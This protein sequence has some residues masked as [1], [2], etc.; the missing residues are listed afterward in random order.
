MIASGIWAAVFKPL[1]MWAG[2]WLQNASVRMPA[3][4]FPS[5]V[6]LGGFI[7]PSGASVCPNENEG[8][9]GTYSVIVQT[10]WNNHVKCQ[11]LY[12]LRGKYRE[13]ATVSA[14][15]CCTKPTPKPC[16]W[17][18]LLFR[19]VCG[20]RVWEQLNREGPPPSQTATE[21]LAKAVA[22]S[23]KNFPA[24]PWGPLHRAASWHSS[25]FLPEASRPR[26]SERISQDGSHSL[27][28]ISSPKWHPITSGLFYPLEANSQSQRYSRGG[29]DTRVW[30]PGGENP[31]GQPKGCLWQL[32]LLFFTNAENELVLLLLLLYIF[33]LNERIPLQRSRL[34]EKK[35][36]ITFPVTNALMYHSNKH[37]RLLCPLQGRHGPSW[38][39]QPARMFSFLEHRHNYSCKLYTKQ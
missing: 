3:S 18:Q 22:I 33:P 19:S 5:S 28:I 24:H 38:V 21:V 9:N 23:W 35:A 25:W 27:F 1:F 30:I 34:E 8:K 32:L 10:R 14:P 15:Y 17:E 7:Y 36:S 29:N 4:L 37:R 13:A 16:A 11:G 6:T 2:L 26:G 31:R 12:L 39:L 20:S